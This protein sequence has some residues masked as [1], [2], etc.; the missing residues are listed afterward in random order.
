[1]RLRPSLLALAGVPLSV[2]SRH[3]RLN[4]T[5]YGLLDLLSAVLHAFLVAL[6]HRSRRRLSPSRPAVRDLG[7][8]VAANL[9]WVGRRGYVCFNSL[10]GHQYDSAVAYDFRQRL[11]HEFRACQGDLGSDRVVSLCVDQYVFRV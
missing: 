1:L 8:T 5:V 6:D 4:A 7:I 2:I 10:W 9:C 3:V 11:S